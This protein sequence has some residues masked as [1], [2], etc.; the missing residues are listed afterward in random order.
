VKKIEVKA[1][2]LK[3]Y[4]KV[5]KLWSE[6]ASQFK[7]FG[8]DS[9]Q[10]MSEALAANSE[11]LW[12][13]FDGERLVGTVMATHDTRKAEVSRL[14]VHPNYR[15]Q[16]VASKLLE[17]AENAL[18]K[19]GVEIKYAIVFKNNEESLG[20]FKKRGYRLHEDVYYVSKRPRQD[21]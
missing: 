20:F 3:D 2:T 10:K 1:L 6:W 16:G 7:P 15:R 13:A 19:Q 9:E 5:K 21:A 4:E 17:A 18:K 8:R 11:C 12:G 14:V